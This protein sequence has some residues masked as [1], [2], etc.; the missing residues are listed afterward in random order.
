MEKTLKSPVNFTFKRRSGFLFK[1]RIVEV[2]VDC[3]FR[4]GELEHI[5][6]SIGYDE[7]NLTYTSRGRDIIRRVGEL[8]DTP[9]W[10]RNHNAF[11]SGN[12]LGA[13]ARGSGNVY[14]E[15]EKGNPVYD[16]TVL[17]K[18]YDV[19]VRSNCK[20]IIELGFMPDDLSSGPP[21]GYIRREEPLAL[22]CTLPSVKGPFP[23]KDYMK[24]RNLVYETVKHLRE[25]YGAEEIESWYLEVWNEPDVEYW[26]GTLKEYFKLYDY[27][28]DGAVAAH[29]RIKIGG[30][31]TTSRGFDFFDRF[32]AHCDHGENYATGGKGSRLDFISFHSK[33]AP[34]PRTKAERVQSSLKKIIKDLETYREV[35][36]KYPR[37]AKLPCFYDECDPSV[38]TILGRYDNSSYIFRVNEYYAGFLCRLAKNL[39][40]FKYKFG[41]NLKLF[42]TWAFYFEGKR[43]FEGNR[44]LFT[45]NNVKKPVFNAFDALSRMGKTRVALTTSY[46]DDPIPYPAYELPVDGLAS[47]SDNEA[48]IM[49]WYFDDNWEATGKVKI[50][51][52]VSN[53]PF[54]SNLVKY[55]H[56]R[57]DGDHSNS[58]SEWVRQ[59]EPQDPSDEQIKA[60]KVRQ[61]LEVYEEIQGWEAEDKKFKR[62]FTLPMHGVSL[63]TLTPSDSS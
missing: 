32:L 41:L 16:W 31:A 50:S 58:F 33:G 51:L 14:S 2:K 17:D 25:R 59:G 23:P 44:S 12:E 43:Y 53:L 5:W 29:P 11:T 7:I 20:P 39:V 38:G 46:S 54:E 13:P 57:I 42:T 1:E 10:I 28:V 37:F 3:S 24:W 34:W 56:Y 6:R 21:E 22:L 62:L 52:E 15:D 40:D 49:I 19:F 61:D 60:I 45:N 35:I 55:I 18:V 48:E 47:I 36:S 27:A 63:I 26:E 30:P 9:Y 4:L 8:K